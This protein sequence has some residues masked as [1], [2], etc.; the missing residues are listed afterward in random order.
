MERREDEKE[1]GKGIVKER[2][3]EKGKEGGERKGKGW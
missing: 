3:K 1:K 2:R